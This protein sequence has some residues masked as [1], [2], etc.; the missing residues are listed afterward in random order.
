VTKQDCLC[1]FLLIEKYILRHRHYSRWFS[2]GSKHYFKAK[3]SCTKD[4]SEESQNT[5]NVKGKNATT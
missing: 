5:F 4:S 3:K 1:T 2:K